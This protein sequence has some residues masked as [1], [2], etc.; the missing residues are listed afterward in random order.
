M[1]QTRPG[2]HLWQAAHPDWEPGSG[3]DQLVTS[4]ALDHDQRLL[5]IDP[6]APPPELDLMAAGREVTIVVTCGWHRRDADALAARLG[7]T[8]FVPAPDP[9]HPDPGEGRIY[10]AGDP[11]MPAVTALAGMEPGDMLLWDERHRAL[12]AG[13]TMID[14]GGGLCVPYDWA[15]EPSDREHIRT[16]LLHLL[17][18][19]IG[20]VLP[21][22]GL[23]T[24]S[25]A[26]RHALTSR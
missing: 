6:L 5:V 24:G 10:A 16:G 23:P 17:E 4:Y 15:D 3:W 20:V 12:I 13:D 19:P 22:H 9:A 7:A 14:R 25:A 26:L 18:L 1:L 21:T 8:L 11:I 2:V